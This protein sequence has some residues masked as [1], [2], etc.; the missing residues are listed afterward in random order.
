MNKL[1][2][3]SAP[4]HVYRFDRFASLMASLV[5][6]LVLAGWA[7]EVEILK[8]LVPILVA[9]NPVTATAFI[10]LSVSV[11]ASH[12]EN[13]SKV[14]VTAARCSALVVLFIGTLKLCEITFGWFTGID[15]ILFRD[16]LSWDPT[17]MPNRMAPNTALNFV[18]L[19]V[20]MIFPWRKHR[21]RF[22]LSTALILI[23]IFGSF[24]PIIGYLYG[25][26]SFYGIGQ[27][28][29][30]ALHT[31]FT[32][33]MLGVG[34]LFAQPERPI[35]ATLFDKGMS[36]IMVRRLLP[37]VIAMPIMLA[38]FRLKGQK[39]GLY[40][41]ELGAALAVVI[42]ILV[43]AAIVWWNSFLLLRLDKQRKEA[44]NQLSEM[45]LSDD[46]TGLRNRR[47]FMLLAE[48]ELKLARN[49][50]MGIVLWCIYADLDGL[51][52]I[53][54][55]LGHDAGSESIVHTA[56]ILKATFRE[57]DIIARLG[58]DEF[59]ILA[60]TN[61][62]VG[63][64]LLIERLQSNITAFNTGQNLPYKLSLSIGLVPVDTDEML[65]LDA[66]L[67]AAD[68]EMYLNK[69]ARKTATRPDVTTVQ[70]LLLDRNLVG[71]NG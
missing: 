12:S 65:T 8:R 51:K 52:K 49:K 43:L 32:F 9:M 40:D 39:I 34:L 5:G 23:S 36:G 4:P 28:I 35:I 24:L 46:L 48:Q 22:D 31:A 38:W 3:Q 18:L 10:F 37:A 70:R 60:A 58:G 26:R 16:K 13:A 20:A 7:L 56:A 44:E 21:G 27:F 25:T 11:W 50:R 29:P 30:M 61:T 6:I 59:A 17:G 53:N 54:D 64:N 42:Q 69:Q 71:L 15:Q 19:S 41:N 45:V 62:P 33:L 47:G 1:P 2:T 55:T 57:S 67:K 14:A 66:I 68:A 63:G